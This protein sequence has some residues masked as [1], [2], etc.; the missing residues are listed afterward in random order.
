MILDG[1]FYG[2]PNQGRGCLLVF[3]QPKANDMYGAAIE[4]LEPVSKVVDSLY[5]KWALLTAL[6]LVRDGTLRRWPD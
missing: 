4:T 6:Q 1:V 5:A 2:V 3:V